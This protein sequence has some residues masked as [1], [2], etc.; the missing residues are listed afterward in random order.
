MQFSRFVKVDIMEPSDRQTSTAHTD[1]ELL[2]ESYTRR[3]SIHLLKRCKN[4]S[5]LWPST[6]ARIGDVGGKQLGN[7]TCNI[8]SLLRD[9]EI[10][11]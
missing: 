10:E 11:S 2:Y 5:V 1:G 6:L 8:L 3:F 7:K 9:G 4:L